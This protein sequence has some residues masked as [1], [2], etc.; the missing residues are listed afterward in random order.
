[1]VTE[2]RAAK[3]KNGKWKLYECL[4]GGLNDEKNIVLVNTSNNF[5]VTIQREEFVE[6]VKRYF[7]IKGY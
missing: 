7:E 2:D 3:S 5:A 4:N 6:V 1:M